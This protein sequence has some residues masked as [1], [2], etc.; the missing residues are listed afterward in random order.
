MIVT[1]RQDV[2]SLPEGDAFIHW[3]TPLSADSVQELKD[4]LKL[5]ERKISRSVS[6][7]SEKT[8]TATID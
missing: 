1:M 4:W 8:D 3:P 7:P 2:F 6:E 5:V